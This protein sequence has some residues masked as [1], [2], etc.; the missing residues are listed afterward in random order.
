MIFENE[1]LEEIVDYLGNFKYSPM[2]REMLLDHG[3]EE[4]ITP[5]GLFT[6]LTDYFINVLIK[7]NAFITQE[8]K[9]IYD[10]LEKV[11]IEYKKY[12]NDSDENNIFTGI[13]TCFFENLSNRLMNKEEFKPERIFPYLGKFSIHCFKLLDE[14][15]GGPTP[16]LWT[17]EEWQE[18]RSY[19]RT[20]RLERR[21]EI[22]ENILKEIRKN[23]DN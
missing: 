3:M 16:G 23:S 19:G 8:E 4:Y 11:L 18:S 1:K 13:T 7:E 22:G 9:D 5:C 14:Y 12:P 15:M 21:A 17:D 2:F 20:K 10:F 6:V